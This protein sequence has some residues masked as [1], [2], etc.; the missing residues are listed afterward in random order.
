MV[1]KNEELLRTY[2]PA[3]FADS[4][5]DRV[6]GR[7]TFLPTTEILEILQDEGWTTWKAQ[8]VKPR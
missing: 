3:A 6:S 1:I 5:E 4:P 7:Y 8:P 2:A